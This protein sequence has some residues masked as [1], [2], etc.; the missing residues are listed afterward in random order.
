M[1]RIC[2]TCEA[3]I[4]CSGKCASFSRAVYLPSSREITTD[5]APAG[6]TPLRDKY[7]ALLNRNV[8]RA[9]SLTRLM[10][11]KFLLQ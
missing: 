8:F 5:Q 3:F 9:V 2:S 7:R 10:P 1:P 11:P 4:Y 6:Y